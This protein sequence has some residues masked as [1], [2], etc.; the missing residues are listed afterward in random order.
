MLPLCI[1]FSLFPS[2]CSTTHFC[3]PC[4]DRPGDGPEQERTGRLPKCPAGPLGKQL[5]GE[6]TLKGKHPDPGTEFVLGC[7][8]CRN[9]ATF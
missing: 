4:H 5:T 7:S 9:A 1:D 2:P 8:I 3:N 6:C